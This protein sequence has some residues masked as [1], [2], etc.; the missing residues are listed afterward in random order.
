MEFFQQ[1]SPVLWALPVISASIGWFTN[2]LAVKM[3]TRPV[4]PIKLLGMRIQGVIPRRHHD[5]AEKISQAVAKDF[6]TSDDLKATIAKIDIKPVIRH[7]IEKKWE[8]KIGEILDVVPMIKMF[9]PEDKLDM[10]RD[11]IIDA[12]SNDHDSLNE[13]FADIISG[14]V[15]LAGI[16]KKNIEDFP[17]EKLESIINEIAQKEFVFIERLGGIIGFFIGV[18]QVLLVVAFDAQ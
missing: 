15:D 7:M 9:V 4:H 3:L 14:K 6:L 18:I 5:L 16:I 11:K 8:E 17:L 1:F 2:Y 10:I 12:F 13:D